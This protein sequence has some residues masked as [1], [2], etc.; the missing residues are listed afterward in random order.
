MR[1]A[2]REKVAAAPL[3]E[4]CLNLSKREVEKILLA[5]SAN[6]EK[7][8][9]RVK[10]AP[11]NK[12]E[13]RAFMGEA[14]FNRAK[15]LYAT[16]SVSELLEA[17]LKALIAKKEKD[18]GKIDRTFPEKQLST[19]DPDSRY[20]PAA[21]KRAIHNRSQ[22]Q[23]ELTDGTTRCPSKKHLEIDHV[24]PFAQGLQIVPENLRH[25]YRE[26]NQYAARKAGSRGSFL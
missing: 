22:G 20:I 16:D 24:K 21:I 5:K 1:R 17:A 3:V 11:N 23:C 12:V 8:K 9:E 7:Y 6:P 14:L 4:K 2:A 26:H 10:A 19:N 15:E 13:I 18:L 25:L